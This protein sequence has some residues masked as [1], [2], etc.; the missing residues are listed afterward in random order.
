MVCV[1]NGF[2]HLDNVTHLWPLVSIRINA[3]EAN[4]D[5]P[6]KGTFWWLNLEVWI[7]YLLCPLT[8]NHHLKP[9]YEIHLKQTIEEV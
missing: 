6:L 1:L 9:L 2:K 3:L 5:C 4:Q 7:H 8:G